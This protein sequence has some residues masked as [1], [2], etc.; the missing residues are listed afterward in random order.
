[1]NDPTHYAELLC[2]LAKKSLATTATTFLN[3]IA[4]QMGAKA[5]LVMSFENPDGNL[6]LMR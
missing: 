4:R 5:H 1:M 6:K 3:N 2:R